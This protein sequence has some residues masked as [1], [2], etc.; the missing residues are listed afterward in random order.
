TPEQNGQLGAGVKPGTANPDQNTEV[1]PDD[2]GNPK[3]GTN[4]PDQN[5]QAG[6]GTTGATGTPAPDTNNGSTGTPGQTTPSG[7][8]N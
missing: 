3:P 6:Q 1:K 7:Q 8:D 4:T 2:N 5:N